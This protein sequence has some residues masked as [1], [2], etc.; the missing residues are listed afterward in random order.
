MRTENTSLVLNGSYG[1]GGAA[2]LRTALIMSAFTDR[3]VRMHSIRGAKRK[4]GLWPEDLTFAQALALSAGAKLSGDELGSDELTF[5]PSRR[6]RA[7]K[8][9][10][11][12]GEHETGTLPGNA[13]VVLESL[14]PVL[15]RTGSY[16]GVT[17]IGETYNNNTLSFDVWER[18][19]LVAHKR[20]GIYAFPTQN[21]AGFGYGARG[22]VVMEVEPS[23]I[24]G[25]DW[26]R[27]GELKRL[28]AV[29]A[30]AELPESIAQR[31]AEHAERLMKKYSGIAVAEISP[32]RSRGAGVFVSMVA[33]FQQGIGCASAM[34]SRGVR[35]ETVVEQCWSQ[36]KSW[37][38]SEAT[39]DPYLAD[40]L[41]I[42]ALFASSPTV[43][44]VSQITSRLLTQ[45]WIIKQ[46]MPIHF[47]VLGREGEPGTISIE[48]G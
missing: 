20:Q 31:G 40:Q 15:A 44:K 43:L 13:V 11:D 34:G 9:K 28:E 2:S 8:T 18:G 14:L 17:V 33:E 37:L 22:E 16:S 24:N 42:P 30:Y 19:T 29:V 46:F 36:M 27:R 38:E 45:A 1:E 32:V 48:P 12:I 4:P 41:V 25:L 7:L 47:T 3:P 5:Q 39:V 23:A 35:M 26:A 21:T 10:F 6:P